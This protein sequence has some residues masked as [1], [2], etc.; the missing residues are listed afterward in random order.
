MVNFES[1]RTA[2]K[3]AI[4]VVADFLSPFSTNSKKYFIRN[5][6]SVYRIAHIPGFKVLYKYFWHSTNSF[7]IVSPVTV[8]NLFFLNFRK[9]SLGKS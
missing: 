2:V 3:L 5:R 4:I 8:K 9:Y 1:S 7:M 6:N